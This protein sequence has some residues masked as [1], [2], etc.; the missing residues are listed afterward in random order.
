[1]LLPTP[2]MVF[3]NRLPRRLTFIMPQSTLPSARFVSCLALLVL[4]QSVGCDANPDRKRTYPVSGTVLVDGA[5]AANLAVRAHP[6]GGMDQNDPTVSSAFTD[7]AGKFTFSTFETG[8]GI[9]EGEYK[10][11]FEWGEMNLM[12]MQYGGPDKLK[13]RYKD[14]GKSETVIKVGPQQPEDLGNINLTTK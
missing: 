4:L 9:P 12:S 1:M 2:G 11:T 5:P 6:T 8:D 3:T 7:T 14:P 13:N 10:L